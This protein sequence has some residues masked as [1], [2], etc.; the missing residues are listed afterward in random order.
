MAKVIY[1]KDP[2]KFIP[3][4]AEALKNIPEFAIP[5]WALFS[6]SGSSRQRPPVSDDFWY[7]RAASILR[8]LYI[9]GVVG[10][11][12]LRTRYGSRKDRGGRPDKFKK[13]GGKIIRLILQQAEAAGLVEKLSRL[14]F[15]RRLTAK[16]RELLD[17]IE[18]EETSGLDFESVKVETVPVEQEVP[19]E[20][21][22]EAEES[23]EET[24]SQKDES[25]EPKTETKDEEVENAK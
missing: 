22:E 18:V 16:G 3:A 13:A 24:E 17:S 1:A 20:V 11:G 14:Q 8:Q 23:A 7:T 15:G 25:S 9:K 2:V 5:E 21:T 19:E 12:K 4:L 10:V 6:K